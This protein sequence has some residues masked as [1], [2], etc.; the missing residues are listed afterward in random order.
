[1]LHFLHFSHPLRI[2]LFIDERL[3]RALTI[4][5]ITLVSAARITSIRI[6]SAG[7]LL[8]LISLLLLLRTFFN[9]LLHL[10]RFFFLHSLFSPY[11]C[12]LQ[13]LQF[14]LLLLVAQE[15]LREQLLLVVILNRKRF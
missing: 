3:N 6:A 7:R 2:L 10:L 9:L 15:F 12:L 4:H 8:R 1:M 5:A 14:V 13:Q 11:L